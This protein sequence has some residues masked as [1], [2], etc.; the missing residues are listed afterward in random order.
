MNI[1]N[2]YSFL[3]S[4]I[5]NQGS[6]NS[7]QGIQLGKIISVSPLTVSIGD[8]QLTSN[9]LLLADYLKGGYAREMSANGVESL[10]TAKSSLQS[11]DALAL[12]KVNST[13]FLIL[14]KVVLP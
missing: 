4:T 8:L 14:C 6:I 13:T 12:V 10:Y 9:N 11:G 1:G 3:V 2:P 7:F 5:R